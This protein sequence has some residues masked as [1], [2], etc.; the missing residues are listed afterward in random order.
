MSDRKDDFLRFDWGERL[1]STGRLAISAGHLG[2]RR[3]IGLEGETDARIGEDLARELD[4]MKGM[5]MK[6][7][8]ILSYFDGV[9]PEQTHQA[10]HALQIGVTA[11][12][13]E[14]VRT[15]LDDAFGMPV[16]DLFEAFQYVPVAAA[17]IGQ[18]H[19]AR[20]QGR[21][22][23]VKIQYPDIR[24]SIE[25][26]FRRLR[27]IGKTISL[28]PIAADGDAIVEELR[29]R[30]L[31]ECD[32]EAEAI[33]QEQFRRAFENDPVLSVPT[34]FA[35]RTRNAVIT[36]E[37]MEGSNFYTFARD[38]TAEQHGAAAVA[39]IRFAYRSFY[40]LG[41]INADP[42]PGN[43]LF[44]NDGRIILLDFGCTRRFESEFVERERKVVRAV[45]DGDRSSF[46]GAVIETDIVAEPGRFDFDIH[47]KMLR[48]LYAPFIQDRFRFSTDFIR[49]G[50]EFNMPGNPNLLRLRIPPPWIWLQRL[51]WGLHA[52]L[53]RME[54][55]GS[56]RD[57]FRA[58][59]ESDLRPPHD[60]TSA[61]SP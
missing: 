45:V 59:L 37:W 9:L 54:A 61:I 39:L 26:D 36:T 5:A 1:W 51:Q 55:E 8:Q 56:F 53:A 13:E 47:W 16:E 7:G 34:V 50:M 18:V 48:H 24:E 25:S 21:D 19:R 41:T 43:Y 38:A 49:E 58:A 6:I 60:E 52:V 44:R 29:D 10:L 20:Y 28:L 57:V 11:M 46:E 27:R 14:R 17:S 23:A 31:L 42:H 12:N 3:L 35:D 4:Q 33:A 32:Y 40:E 15:V 2:F 30:V 22:V